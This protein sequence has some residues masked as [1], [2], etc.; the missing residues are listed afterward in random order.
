MSILKF[1]ED[2][3]I[4]DNCKMVFSYTFEAT[5]KGISYNS[6]EGYKTDM[7]LRFLDLL[8]TNDSGEEINV[9]RADFDELNNRIIRDRKSVV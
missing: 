7:V 2:E 6:K 3:S 5:H 9:I 4:T 1:S 8:K